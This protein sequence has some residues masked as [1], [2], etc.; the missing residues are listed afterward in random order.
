MADNQKKLPLYTQ[1]KNK[2]VRN[3]KEGKW[4]EGETIP[5]ESQLMEYYNVSRTTI[6]QAVRELVQAGILE[7]RRGAPTKVRLRPKVDMNNPGI[8]HHEQ[9]HNLTVKV[10]RAEDTNRHYF[11]A[12]QLKRPDEEEL[13]SLD[14]LRFADDRPI[15]IQQMYL[16]AE[17]GEKI[18]DK[19]GTDFDLFPH[20]G[21]FNIH[22]TTI[23]E[24][25]SACNATRY[26]ADLLGI[27][28]GEAL[29]VIER[30]TFG[31]DYLPMEY[32]RTKYLPASFQYK[33]EIGN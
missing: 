33:I 30:V 32:S 8:I 6:R 23:K 11:A 31:L 22:Y 2:M 19:T 10:L 3:I 13:F 21:R 5:S 27:S 12:R 14:R 9:G 28:P 16:P 7:T 15:A 29:I 4:N 24:N 18:K 26:E 17:I 25:V 20:L 1:I